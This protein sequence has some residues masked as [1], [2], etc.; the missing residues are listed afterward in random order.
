MKTLLRSLHRG[1]LYGPGSLPTAGHGA[2]ALNYKV[3][4]IAQRNVNSGFTG[5]SSPA[6]S[7]MCAR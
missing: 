4:E 5:R 3:I 6:L 1:M 7:L 2:L